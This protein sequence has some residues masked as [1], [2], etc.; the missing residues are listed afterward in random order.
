MPGVGVTL[1]QT[2]GRVETAFAHVK[3]VSS[4]NVVRLVFVLGFFLL[5]AG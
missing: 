2:R 3:K 1:K 5:L 4:L